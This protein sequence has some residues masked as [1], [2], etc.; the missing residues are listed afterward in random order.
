M[1]GTC[2]IAREADQ[3]VIFPIQC[4][5]GNGERVL[6][7]R[8]LLRPLNQKI[9]LS[10][11]S[12]HREQ[13]QKPPDTLADLLCQSR[14]ADEL[15]WQRWNEDFV[16]SSG[17]S[18]SISGLKSTLHIHASDKASTSSGGNTDLLSFPESKAIFSRSFRHPECHHE[19]SH[20]G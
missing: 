5:P 8:V 14:P 16:L 10:K 1:K 7:E 19:R 12:W 11:T 15:H 17:S 13:C 9:G 4:Q 2:E 20:Q 6:R 3:I 18:N